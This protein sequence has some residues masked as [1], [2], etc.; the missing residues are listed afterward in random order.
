MYA[1]GT[2]CD[3][4]SVRQYL[5][6]FVKP[7]LVLVL[8][9]LLLCACGGSDPSPADL[10]PANL[11]RFDPNVVA[12]VERQMAR[13]KSHPRAG[14]SY[15]ELGMIYEANLLWARCEARVCSSGRVGAGVD[16]VALSPGGCN[17]H[18]R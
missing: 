18:R 4:H 5:Q 16:V 17:S 3:F 7:P 1:P 13:I 15:A 6:S 12:L 10:V 11:S 8:T 2:R 9:T 14:A